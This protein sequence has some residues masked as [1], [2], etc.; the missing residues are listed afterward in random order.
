[1]S[2]YGTRIT[3]LSKMGTPGKAEGPETLRLMIDLRLSLQIAGSFQGNFC[4]IPYIPPS[5]IAQQGDGDIRLV[6]TALD[7]ANNFVP[8]DLSAAT[9]L[10]ILFKKPDLTTQSF[11]ATLTTNGKDGKLSYNLNASDLDQAGYYSV[12]GNFSI[13]SVPKST[14]LGSFKV[15]ENI[16]I[17]E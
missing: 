2:I 11:V 9:D 12:Q 3:A 17:E 1:M 8:V 4:D 10:T 5:Q 15:A 16:V 7:G 14:I 6:I 13:A